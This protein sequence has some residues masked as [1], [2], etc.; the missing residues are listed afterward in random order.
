MNNGVRIVCVKLLTQGDVDIEARHVPF[1]ICADF[2][3]SPALQ[4][5]IHSA[6]YITDMPRTAY[7]RCPSTRRPVYPLIRL[8][9]SIE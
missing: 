3:H 5:F 1:N 4:L 9:Q 2:A 6:V 7:S 8:L